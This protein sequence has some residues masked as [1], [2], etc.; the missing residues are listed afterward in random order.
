MHRDRVWAQ[1]P[2]EEQVNSSNQGGA[3]AYGEFD[4]LDLWRLP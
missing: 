4:R 1:M 2:P 3:Y